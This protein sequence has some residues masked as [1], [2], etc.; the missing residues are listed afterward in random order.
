VPVPGLGTV[1]DDIGAGDVF[2]AA[3][4]TALARGESAREAVAFAH[5][6][7]A[8][9]IGGKGPGAIGDASEIASRA[10]ALS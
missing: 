4:F 6:A 1:R 2:A 7:A 8:V 10:R 9:R 3:L 5:A